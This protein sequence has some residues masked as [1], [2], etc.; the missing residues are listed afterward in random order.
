[1]TEQE[2]LINSLKREIKDYDDLLKGIKDS[3]E[4]V[5]SIQERKREAEAKLLLL[6][7]APSDF[8]AETGPRYFPSQLEDEGKLTRMTGDF[9]GAVKPLFH[10][11]N[12]TAGTSS[13]SEMAFHYLNSD[14][15]WKKPPDWIEV[16]AAFSKIAEYKAKKS[17]LP[18]KLDKI[19]RDLGEKFLFT[20]TTI[21]KAKSKITGVDQAT[22]HM[23]DVL[24]QSW[25]GLLELARKK[26]SQKLLSLEFKKPSDR[27]VIAEILG[28][29]ENK[30]N[31]LVLL[32]ENMYIL[33]G[34]LSKTDLTKNPLSNDVAR[35]NELFDRWIIQI[36][37]LVNILGI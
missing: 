35:M 36:D 14:N 21:E 27:S 24:Q 3:N 18:I 17:D 6:E 2:E 7:K 28:E 37:D 34:D 15:T 13:A 1:M 9:S 31:K 5:P 11:M 8:I 30:K 29:D 19:N 26:S 22:L 10:F 23:R 12:S 4:S 25:A 33:H 20:L 32:L 16:A